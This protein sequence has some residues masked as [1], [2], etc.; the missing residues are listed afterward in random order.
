VSEVAELAQIRELLDCVDIEHVYSVDDRHA[1]G[2]ELARNLG[3][4]LDAEQRAKLLGRDDDAEIL[5]DFVFY[6]QLLEELWEQLGESA[7]TELV[8]RAQEMVGDSDVADDTEALSKLGQLLQERVVALSKAQWEEQQDTVL[9][10]D[11]PIL[12]LFDRDFHAEGGGERDGEDMIRQVQERSVDRPVWTGLLTHTVGAGDEHETYLK[13]GDEG[14]D[15]HRTLVI[16]KTRVITPEQFPSHLRLTLLAPLMHKLVSRIADKVT[17]TQEAA[18]REAKSVLPIELES[19]VFGAS[20]VEGVWPTDTLLLLFGLIQ[21]DSVREKLWDDPDVQSLTRTIRCLGEVGSS[22]PVADRQAAEGDDDED[23]GDPGAPDYR[24]PRFYQRQQIYADVTRVNRLHQP[25]ECGDIF[26]NA[27][28]PSKRWVVIAQPCDLVVRSDGKRGSFPVSHVVVA[29]IKKLRD[30]DEP[31]EGDFKLPY[32]ES[33]GQ[34]AVAQLNRAR[35]QRLWLL[36]L[37]VFDPDGRARLHI[38]SEVPVGLV[39]GWGRRF[40]QLRT[41]A[42]ELL[43]LADRDAKGLRR[44]LELDPPTPTQDVEDLVSEVRRAVATDHAN[45]PFTMTLDP[46]AG[47][48]DSGCQRT[49]R[50]TDEY[51]R[52][53]LSRFGAHL[54]R[55]VLPYDL[56]RLPR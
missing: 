26:S 45:P 35:Y 51:A 53:L 16:S 27:A 13:L 46:D 32:F 8:R 29:P 38:A 28:A 34:H 44:A 42:E 15:L 54:S 50:L 36:D 6:E 22:V 33:T 21:R 31:R 55:P 25:I 2:L 7:R 52:A 49:G 19:M 23:A 18:V 5:E 3:R 39:D 1:P 37:A 24:G 9:E 20:Q 12:I 41:D 43:S 40:V 56:T 17:E 14:I 48:L 4:R 47:T 30:G 10:Q 11:K